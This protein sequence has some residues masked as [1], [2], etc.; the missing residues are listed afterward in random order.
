M[1]LKVLL[2][3][4]LL[5]IL[6]SQAQGDCKYENIEND[7]GSNIAVC[8]E[9]TNN[10][11]K[12]L[13][14]LNLRPTNE[15]IIN[16]T[17]ITQL[18][19][20][21]SAGGS[22]SR[23]HSIK[24]VDNPELT[25]IDD[26]AF[27]P[28]PNIE[29]ILIKNNKL[30]KIYGKTFQGFDN[31][32]SIDLSN[33][34]IYSFGKYSFKKL[35]V[36]TSLDLSYNPIKTLKSHY[37]DDLDNLE[38]LTL[39][40]T[41]L[42]KIKSFFDAMPNLQILNLN[43][44]EIKS[45]SHNAFGKLGNLKNLDLS[46]NFLHS[47][48]KKTFSKLENLEK[49]DL[50]FN[51]L[52][53]IRRN[54]FQG[55]GNL[56]TLVLSNSEFQTFD[57]RWLEE[58]STLESLDISNNNLFDLD[59]D[60]LIKSAPNLKEINL[61]GNRFV[62]SKL[63]KILNKLEERN[64][65][66]A[67]SCNDGSINDTEECPDPKEASE[68][69]N[70]EEI[71]DEKEPRTISSTEN[72]NVENTEE[73]VVQAASENE[74]SEPI[75]PLTLPKEK[76]PTEEGSTQSPSPIEGDLT[77]RKEDEVPSDLEDFVEPEEVGNRAELEPF[78]ETIKIEKRDVRKKNC[79]KRQSGLEQCTIPEGTASFVKGVYCSNVTEVELVTEKKKHKKHWWFG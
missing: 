65:I 35:P 71:I 67:K 75:T 34:K 26:D 43:N 54:P 61:T 77:S 60:L 10:D 21:F 46:H 33:N 62:C 4:V 3:A 57:P 17:R 52:K 29:T 36:L 22:H 56:K 58:M 42:K 64:I 16:S 59:E 27:M 47:L 30:K 14:S 53:N 39:T 48:S 37:F 63:E 73:P 41:K 5:T 28:F 2:P 50:S 19:D 70:S 15:L 25:K 8:E 66:Y 44:N 76:E 68:E 72:I 38:T 32:K 1:E 12:E 6:S 18:D 9:V 40:F 31:L 45:V 11:L 78:E 79:E 69:I 74:T 13:F 55:L 20:E 7:E 24:I 51:N 49:L 23:L